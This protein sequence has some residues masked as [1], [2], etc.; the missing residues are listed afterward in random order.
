[1]SNPKTS[2][3]LPCKC[4][5]TRPDGTTRAT[6][7]ASS[8]EHAQHRARRILKKG[9]L[10]KGWTLTVDGKAADVLATFEGVTNA[11]QARRVAA[12]CLH[13]EDML[14]GAIKQG[15][16]L[17]RQFQDAFGL[18]GA[19]WPELVAAA[20]NARAARDS[21]RTLLGI[22]PEHGGT[23]TEAIK[24]LQHDLAEARQD[25]DR[26]IADNRI[27]LGGVEHAEQERTITMQKFGQLR[28]RAQQVVRM[29]DAGNLSGKGDS[30]AIDLLREAL[31]P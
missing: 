25:R 11:D 10:P 19:S 31:R 28:N 20:K 8:A 4:R 6:F 1:M 3:A 23:I 17:G 15:A 22:P 27:A 7:R 5:L 26:A 24:A 14:A 13:T 30:K 9:A 18:P 12:R 29:H 16:E 21:H 2:P